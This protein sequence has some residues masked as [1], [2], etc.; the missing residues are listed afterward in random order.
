MAE[1][2]HDA[3]LEADHGTPPIS[4]RGASVRLRDQERG[5][6]RAGGHRMDPANQS[7]ADAL[8]FTFRLL[9]VVMVLLIVVFIFSGFKTINEGERGIRVVLGKPQALNL[10]P[11]FHINAPYPLGEMIRIGEGTVET[12]IG[13]AFMPYSSGNRTD[14]AAMTAKVDE[15]T[16]DSNLKPG[17]AGSNITADLNIA[18]TQWTV[19]YQREDHESWA[20]NI[21]PAQEERIVRLAVQRGVVQAIAGT[22][23][24]ELLKQSGGSLA[25]RVRETAQ[26]TLDEM[27]SGIRIDR[28]TL[29]RKI[30]PTYLL[31]KFASVQAAAQN[32]AKSREDA[33]LKRDQR[34]NEVAGAAAPAL[35]ERIN[36]YERLIELGEQDEAAALLTVI[37]ALIEGRPV[38]VA[39][40]AYP[41]GLVS[42]AV[43]EILQ[44]ARGESSAMVSRAIADRDLFR[45]KLKQFESNPSL[46]IARDWSA[47]LGMFLNKPFVQV[48][49]LP[50][51]MDT[52]ELL[53]NEDPAIVR[54][55]DRE[56]KRREALEAKEQRQEA[57][58]RDLYRS[59]RGI[60]EPEE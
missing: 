42:G 28:V 14:A 20:T 59:M 52:A 8:R 18:H 13:L 10:A 55:L 17:R 11:G 22:T 23:I 26:A 36:E 57:F 21:I 45:A 3:G 43:S 40:Q 29:S 38:E 39:G 31:D 1:H 48:M 46:M 60:K 6:G 37:D 35:I 15:F 34:L 30:P 32:A 49:Y 2:D 41:A 25:A 51:N 56:R 24:D 33:L 4:S 9:Q 53:I 12:R 5:G 50:E 44:Q 58:R 16:T 47:A 19:N 7:L 54:E 27:D